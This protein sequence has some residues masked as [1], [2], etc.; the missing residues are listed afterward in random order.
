MLRN[1]LLRYIRGQSS[2]GKQSIKKQIEK[3]MGGDCRSAHTVTHKIKP[4]ERVNLQIVIDLWVKNQKNEVVIRGYSSVAWEHDIGL[5]QTIA[6]NSLVV[7]PVEREQLPLENG[8][9]LDCISRGVYLMRFKEQ[10]VVI[11]FHTRDMGFKQRGLEIMAHDRATAHAALS[12]LLSDANRQNVYKGK[13]I[14]LET[15]QEWQKEITVKF[16]ELPMAARDKIVLP[17]AV[18]RV[19]ERNVLSILQH[20]ETL[21][22]SGRNARHG[23]LFH[24]PPGTGKTLVL[25]Y[26]AKSCPTHTVILLTG[27]QLGLIRESCQL[28]RL[29]APSIMIL[30][31]VDLVAE[32]R[33]Q[34]NTCSRGLLHDLLDEMDGIG[35]K[36]EVIFLLTTNRPDMIEPALSAR[37]GRID[38]AIEFPLPDDDC[39]QRLFQLYGAGLDLNKV[40]AKRWIA[41]TQGVSPAFIEELLRKAALMA[42]ERGETSVPLPVTDDDIAEALKELVYFGGAVTQKLLGYKPSGANA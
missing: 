30:E 5:A 11:L 3:H 20:R 4:F 38:Q 10:P 24:G 7:A 34:N 15:E 35:T 23:V 22:K 27:R 29:L 14:S 17:D 28:A 39:R 19:V 41:Q 40:D 8:Q 13:T 42:A 6:R 33:T 26:L 12:Q 1:A 2:P 37:P 32:E 31:D 9:S 25:R 36:A 18:M 21:V 16:H